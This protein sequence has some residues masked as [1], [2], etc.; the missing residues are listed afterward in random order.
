MN[1]NSISKITA[2]IKLLKSKN[3]DGFMIPSCDEFQSEYVPEYADRLKY[4]CGFTGSNGIAVITL[5]NNYFFTDGRYF[6]QAEKEIDSSFSVYDINDFFCEGKIGFDPK[7]HLRLPENNSSIFEFVECE[8]LIDLIWTDK[9]KPTT[10]IIFDYPIKYAGASP[11]EKKEFLQKYLIKNNIDAII[12]SKPE[13]S[14]WLLN[15]RAHDIEYNPILI[16][17]SIFHRDGTVEVFANHPKFLPL[18]S[19]YLALEKLQHKKI[20]LDDQSASIWLKSQFKNPIL[21]EDP[22]YLAKAIKNKVEISQ[23]R[24]V[25]ILDGIAYCKLLYWLEQNYQKNLISEL[26]I[27]EKQL[28]YKKEFKNFIYP[29][30]ATICGFG[31]NGAIIHYRANKE[32]NKIISDNNFLLLDSGSQYFGGTT[33]I[34]RTIGLGKLTNEQKLNYTLVLKGHIALAKAIFPHGTNGS[35]LDILARQFLYK[36]GKNYSHG[37]G[38]GV[39]NCLSV[40]EPPQ[41]INSVNKVILKPGMILSNEPGF[42]KENEYGIRIENLI[43]VKERKKFLEFETLTLAPIDTK[44]I[45]KSLLDKDEINWL[46]DYSNKIFKTLSPYFDQQMNKW[47]KEKCKKL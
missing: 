38:H 28:L 17:Y 16:C 31:D 14:C 9:P 42:Y 6:L 3:I 24:K 19:F 46:N 43:L 32:T 1:N 30:F 11:L 13:N 21:K 26:D 27:I 23:S 22:I 35:Q 2:L 36:Y 10:S 45:I 40:H 41:R 33:D 25:H 4:I 8:N 34:T 37:T 5:K 47:L 20:Q 15:L 12:I 39:G 29:S 7:L 18:E 44:P